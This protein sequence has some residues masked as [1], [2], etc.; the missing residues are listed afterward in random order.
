MT[1]IS[2]TVRQILENIKQQSCESLAL[3]FLFNWMLGT[4]SN[5]LILVPSLPLFPGDASNLI[6]CLLT[7]Q[8]PFQV[9]FLSAPH[10]FRP[11][12]VYSNRHILPST[13]ASLTAVYCVNS[14]ITAA[15]QRFHPVYSFVLARARHPSFDHVPLMLHIIVLSPQ[16]LRV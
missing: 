14:S 5:R 15:I 3:P 16:L 9:G 7:Q 8:L 10:V 12:T 6:G 2:N 11:L 1:S 13:I 4:P